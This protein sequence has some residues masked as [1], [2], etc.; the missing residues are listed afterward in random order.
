MFMG[1]T[2]FMMTA[3]QTM[4]PAQASETYTLIYGNRNVF[5]CCAS[6]LINE[7]KREANRVQIANVNA[8]RISNPLSPSGEWRFAYVRTNLPGYQVY[9][10]PTNGEAPRKLPSV[11]GLSEW[12]HW[13]AEEDTLYY[14]GRV[15]SYETAFHKISPNDPQP[16]QLSRFQFEFGRVRSIQQQPLPNTGGFS[17]YMLFVWS[18]LSL[19]IAG[20]LHHSLVSRDVLA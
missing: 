13:G 9:L 18:V 1:L 4:R 3:I 17:P 2:L 19:T 20:G 15:S 14:L 5:R 16:V 12:M 7:D 6:Y 10:V 8:P 11:V